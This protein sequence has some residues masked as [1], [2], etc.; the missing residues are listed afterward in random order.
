MDRDSVIQILKEF[1]ES[2][3]WKIM[4]AALQE[5]VDDCVKQMSESKLQEL[6]AAEYKVKM[7]ELLNKKEDR[8][9]MMTLPD[10]IIAEASDA[11]GHVPNFD[12]YFTSE[13]LK[14][15]ELE[16]KE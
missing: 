12:P 15:P 8:E 10:L 5:N 7:T 6:P 14:Q 3:G 4:L 2:S 1:K 13:E 16:P 11:E 9:N